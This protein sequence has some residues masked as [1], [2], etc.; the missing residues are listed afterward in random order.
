MPGASPR[1]RRGKRPKSA[2]FAADPPDEVA[3]AA[4]HHADAP[5]ESEPPEPP[6]ETARPPATAKQRKRFDPLGPT[7]HEARYTKE[8]ST[9]SYLNGSHGALSH[10]DPRRKAASARKAAAKS[11]AKYVVKSDLRRDIL[12]ER[13]QTGRI[14]AE[15]AESRR[16][17]VNYFFKHV[18]G[19]PPESTWAG[20]AD[21]RAPRGVRKAQA[22]GRVVQ[23]RTQVE[24]EGAGLSVH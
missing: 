8:T 10:G 1:K 21:T 24:L 6:P 14:S 23:R 18:Y 11:W 12:V 19:A 13:D 9:D 5:D 22:R 7:A 17:A 4:D 20:R 16:H 15:L 3:D 2:A